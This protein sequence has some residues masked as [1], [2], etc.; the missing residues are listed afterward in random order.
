MLIVWKEKINKFIPK[1]IDWLI[2]AVIFLTPLCFA[3]FYEINSVFVLYKVIVLRVLVSL[4]FLL[5][6][7]QLF[8]A[9]SWQYRFGKKIF[10]LII[11]LALSW[12]LAAFFSIN[13]VG[14]LAGSYERQL[15]TK[16]GEVTLT[17][18]KL[19]NLPA[20]PIAQ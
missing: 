2:L 9:G 6:L 7:A 1:A 8:L 5:L 12:A 17:V 19:R 13:P 16:A 14:S 20:I 18:P 10:W 4:A 11:V 15:Q 3:L